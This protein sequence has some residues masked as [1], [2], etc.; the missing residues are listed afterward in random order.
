MIESEEEEKICG[1][2]F[3][4]RDFKFY[5]SVRQSGNN[6]GKCIALFIHKNLVLSGYIV[7]SLM[8]SLLV[9]LCNTIVISRHLYT[10]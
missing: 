9:V 4:G 3:M 1:F 8:S 7:F 6:K 5:L 10:I 2:K